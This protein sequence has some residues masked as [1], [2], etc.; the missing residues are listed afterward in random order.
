MPHPCGRLDLW[1][2]CLASALTPHSAPSTWSLTRLVRRQQAFGLVE[3]E[4]GARLLNLP[5]AS[6]TALEGRPE[7]VVPTFNAFLAS[8]S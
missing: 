2:A 6:Y 3:Q 5:F 8:L 1:R 7:D 4:E